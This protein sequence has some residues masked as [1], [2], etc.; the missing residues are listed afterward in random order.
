MRGTTLVTRGMIVPRLIEESIPEG[1]GP[2]LRRE[3]IIKPIITCS[4]F[5]IDD[6]KS[7]IPTIVEGVKIDVKKVSIRYGIDN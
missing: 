7:K 3:E 1:G 6:K 5:E 2:I 4:K